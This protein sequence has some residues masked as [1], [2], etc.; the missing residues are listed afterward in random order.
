MQ[1]GMGINMRAYNERH[2][3]YMHAWLILDIM[4]TAGMPLAF[5]HG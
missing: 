5:K 1:E 3:R 4:K 2:V